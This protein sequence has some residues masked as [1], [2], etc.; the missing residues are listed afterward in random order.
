MVFRKYM[1]VEEAGYPDIVLDDNGDEYICRYGSPLDTK[2]PA[3]LNMAALMLSGLTAG[4]EGN[5]RERRRS[6]YVYPVMPLEEAGATGNDDSSDTTDGKSKTV[7]SATKQKKTRRTRPPTRTKVT[8]VTAGVKAVKAVR[9]PI[10]APSQGSREDDRRDEGAVA[11][12]GYGLRPKSV[13]KEPAY[14]RWG[15]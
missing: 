4:L 11:R 1:E 13:L 7:D 9:L 8:K 5:A 3:S 2:R 14:R 15:I 10:Y 12:R 6:W